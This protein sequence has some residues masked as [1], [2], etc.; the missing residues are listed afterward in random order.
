MS[1]SHRCTN[2]TIFLNYY[3]CQINTNGDKQIYEPID[4]LTR[5]PNSPW[6]VKHVLYQFHLVTQK[7]DVSGLKK[8]DRGAIIS[9]VKNW[10]TSWVKNCENE[11]EYLNSFSLFTEFMDRPGVK[12]QLGECHSYVMDTYIAVTWIAKKEKLVLYNRLTTRNVDRCTSCPAE[13]ENSSMKWGEMVVNPQQHMHQAVHTINKKSN[14][15]FTV[16]EGHDAKNP[17]TTQN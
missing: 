17:D 11:A 8:A 3:L 9:Q 14:S 16:K 7:F 4:I 13:H 5:D 15:R 1:P 10:I 12:E 6:N 2:A